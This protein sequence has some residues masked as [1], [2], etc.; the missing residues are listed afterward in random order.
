M[1]AY[2]EWTGRRA[3]APGPDQPLARGVDVAQRTCSVSGCG[4]PHNAHGLCSM[5]ERRVQKTGEVGP[6]GSIRAAN[7]G[8]TCSVEGCERPAKHRLLCAMHHFR[9]FKT[10]DVGPAALRR[11]ANGEGT[12]TPDGYRKFVINGRQVKEHTLVMEAHLG[13][14]LAHWENVHHKNG[15][16]LDNRLENLE[17]WVKAQPAGQRAIDLARW[18]ADTYP[19]LVREAAGR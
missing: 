14:R 3:N 12:V 6:A 9:E 16:R 19:D 15:V 7:V 8:R 11:R 13:R 10:G 1:T 17:L 4:R 5:H 18:V 2:N